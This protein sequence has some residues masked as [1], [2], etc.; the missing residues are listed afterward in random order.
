MISIVQYNNQ[1]ELKKLV[2]GSSTTLAATSFTVTTGTWHTLRIDLNGATLRG[3]INGT[4]LLTANDS[5]FSSGN[6]GGATFFASAEFDDFIVTS[7]GPG[8]T[9]TM[10][11]SYHHNWFDDTPQRNPRARFGE[12]AHIFN[13]YYFSNSDVGVACQVSAGCTVEGNY[14]EDVEE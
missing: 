5:Q 12:P 10:R 4:L 13:N 6:V 2:G 7:I 11:V 9:P 8:P 1:L 3:Y 14:F